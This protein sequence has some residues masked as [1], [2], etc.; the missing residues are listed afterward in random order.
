MVSSSSS[1]L[2]NYGSLETRDNNFFYPVF[3]TQW[4]KQV[5][6]LWAC[7]CPAVIK[8]WHLKNNIFWGGGDQ[9]PGPAYIID[10]NDFEWFITCNSILYHF[11]IW[12]INV[13]GHAIDWS[14]IT[15]LLFLCWIS[16]NGRLQFLEVHQLKVSM[17]FGINFFYLTWVMFQ[18]LYAKSL[19]LRLFI[20]CRLLCSLPSKHALMTKHK[21]YTSKGYSCCLQVVWHYTRNYCISLS[22]TVCRVFA[23]INIHFVVI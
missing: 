17:H 19:S 8:V 14:V 23:W 4:V 18:K 20:I 3:R 9:I 7:S 21:W 1:I 15:Q 10:I 12:F 6:V 5:F 11:W 22:T 13:L 2:F 16:R